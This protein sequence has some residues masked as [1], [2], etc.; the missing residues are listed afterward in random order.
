ML[1]LH[2]L[3][4]ALESA[5]G[6]P[7]F[8][9]IYTASLLVG[10][11]A[12]GGGQV[13]QPR[14][15]SRLTAP[16][17]SPAPPRRRAA[18]R[19][20]CTAATAPCRSGP[21]RACTASSRRTWCTACA[22]AP[23]WRGTRATCSGW[24]RCGRAGMQAATRRAHRCTRRPRGPAQRR[25][26]AA[27]FSTSPPRPAPCLPPRSP[28]L[29]ACAPW[30]PLALPAPP[31][32]VVGL[33]LLLFVA[34]GSSLA[35]WWEGSGPREGAAARTAAS[36]PPLCGA[37]TPLAALLARLQGAPGRRCGRRA[38][39]LA[40]G[41]ALPLVVAGAGGRAP[42]AALPWR[43]PLAGL[44]GAAAAGASSLEAHERV[45]DVA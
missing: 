22:T 15:P 21:R 17:P 2:W 8:A 44:E 39:L 38:Q 32:Q 34:A 23:C 29:C 28:A 3:G 20:A 9:A 40:A 24:R 4:P 1:S 31:P 11:R 27:P 18:Q 25:R 12:G 16:C 41:P 26:C 7:R 14:R 42:A 45:A 13:L 33:N 5:A 6:G 37:A 30:D 35:H 43:R 19:S 10:W 36:R